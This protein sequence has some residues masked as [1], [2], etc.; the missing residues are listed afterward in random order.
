MATMLY[1]LAV[2]V[3][4]VL[5]ALLG[6]FVHDQVNHLAALGQGIQRVAL[7]PAIPAPI[8][9]RVGDFGARGVSHVHTLATR[10]GL[11][12][13]LI[14]GA[15][16]LWLYLPGRIA[17]IRNLTAAARVLAGSA[18]LD[19]RRALAMRAALSLPY[20]QLVRFTKDPLGD[21]AAERY[22]GLIAA[23]LDDAGLETR[24]E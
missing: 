11:L 3:G 19:Q 1:D 8:A 16:V 20:G 14:P 4:L 10:M 18:G 7:F 17:Q 22:D 15:L 24:R 2:V 5:L 21:L 6:N 12:T 23:A 13:F 9:G